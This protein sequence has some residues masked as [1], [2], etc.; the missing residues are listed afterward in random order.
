MPKV[1]TEKIIQND[2]IK[3]LELVKMESYNVFKQPT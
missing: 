1:T 3:N 2:M